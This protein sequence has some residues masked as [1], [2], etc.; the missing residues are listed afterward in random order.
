MLK[1]HL[2]GFAKV[3]FSKDTFSDDSDIPTLKGTKKTHEDGNDNIL[4]HWAFTCRADP[5]IAQVPQQESLVGGDQFTTPVLNVASITVNTDRRSSIYFQQ[6]HL[7]QYGNLQL[8]TFSV[9]A[10]SLDH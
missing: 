4:V 7:C 8:I 1:K 2:L 3:Q 9:H 6:K 10:G 5:V